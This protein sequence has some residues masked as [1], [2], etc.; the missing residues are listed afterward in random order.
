MKYWTE[1]LAGWILNCN[2]DHRE[3]YQQPQICRWYHSNGRKWRGTKES[4]D[5]GERGE[6]KSW[7]KIQ[8]SKNEDDGI[9][10]HHLMA[11]RRG[12]SRSSNRFF[13][14]PLDS[15][16]DGD[17]SHEIKRC[18]LLG[19][20]AM[21]NLGSILKS[22]D[23]TLPNKGPSSQSYGFSSSHVWMWELDHTE[24][25]ALENWCF[26]IMLEKILEESLGDQGVQASQS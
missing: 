18:L 12:K 14:F 7:F 13:F 15:T 17:Y 4:L 24:G 8:H 2:Q 11:N 26:W 1:I 16:A 6:W 22:K 5:E 20:K 21:T 9:Q 25:G 10:S 19:R 3:K 23:T